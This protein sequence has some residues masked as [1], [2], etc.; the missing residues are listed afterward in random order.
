MEVNYRILNALDGQGAKTYTLYHD[1]AGD[2]G[3]PA[4]HYTVVVD[5]SGAADKV[6]YFNTAADYRLGKMAIA[7][8]GLR[9]LDPNVR[10]YPV[11]VENFNHRRA[12]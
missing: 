1:D 5:A 8:N 9:Q 6:Y 11:L 3:R 2:T 10:W 7:R 4:H 12:K